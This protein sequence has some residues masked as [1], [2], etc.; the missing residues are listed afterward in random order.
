MTIVVCKLLLMLLMISIDRQT[1]FKFID[2][3]EPLLL[4]C[5]RCGTIAPMWTLWH[6]CSDVDVVALLLRCRRCGTL[7]PMWTLWHS[8]SDV[9]VVALEVHVSSFLAG[10]QGAFSLFH[11]NIHTCLMIGNTKMLYTLRCCW[12]PALEA[13]VYII[14]KFRAFDIERIHHFD[15]MLVVLATIPDLYI[16]ASFVAMVLSK[17]VE[18]VFSDVLSVHSVPIHANILHDGYEQFNRE[19]V[20]RGYSDEQLNF[21]Q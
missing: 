2:L 6:S 19:T 4:R 1:L 10:I 7:A 9:D 14:A 8:C 13:R 5:E 3:F 18:N 17:E 21:R 20:G 12:V 15:K 11:A 16:A